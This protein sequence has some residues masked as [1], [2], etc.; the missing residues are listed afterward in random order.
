MSDSVRPHRWQPTRLPHSRLDP[1]KFGLQN[2]KVCICV[3]FL[4]LN[5]Y[6]LLIFL[7]F[8]YIPE[9]HTARLRTSSS[10]LHVSTA[11][12]RTPSSSSST[13][14]VSTFGSVSA[15]GDWW[16]SG[17]HTSQL[18][19]GC[20]GPLCLDCHHHHH[21]PTGGEGPAKLSVLLPLTRAESGLIVPGN[22]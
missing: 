20:S 21:H 7:L 18:C 5:V 17:G 1:L 9:E 14:H 16:F 8:H 4:F 13:L 10:A 19:I 11:R 22:R 3:Y 2:K 15:V 12:L 6:V